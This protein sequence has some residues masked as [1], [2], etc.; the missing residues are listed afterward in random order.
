MGYHV[1]EMISELETNWILIGIH[2][3]RIA[4]SIDLQLSISGCRF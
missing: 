2:S 1:L 3:M 4:S